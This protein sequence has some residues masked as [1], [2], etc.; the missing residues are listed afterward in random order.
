MEFSYKLS[1]AEYLNGWKLRS[2]QSL[3]PGMIKTILLWAF[4]LACLIL[5]RSFFFQHNIHPSDSAESPVAQPAERGQ[6]LSKLLGDSLPLVGSVIFGAV[7]FI[8]LLRSGLKNMRRRH[9]LKDP[10]MQGTF[11]VRIT[12]SQIEMDN[13]EGCSSQSGWNLYAGWREDKGVAILLLCSGSFEILGLA[14][15]SESEKTELRGILSR[16]LLQK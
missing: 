11:T 2:K 15:L 8:V 5:L 7:V 14:G 4:I 16:A 3:P 12:P 1:E 6:N 9:Y 13:T 10:M